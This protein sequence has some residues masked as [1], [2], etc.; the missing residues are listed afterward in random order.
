MFGKDQLDIRHKKDTPVELW[1]G[2]EWDGKKELKMPQAKFTFT[3]RPAGMRSKG[4]L[5][6]RIQ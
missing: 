3:H 1:T 4:P 6:G 5:P 2:A